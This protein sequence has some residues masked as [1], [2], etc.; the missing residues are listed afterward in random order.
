MSHQMENRRWEG[1]QAQSRHHVA[2]L[3]HR[4]IGHDPLDVVHHQAHGGRK[5]GG[6]AADQCH[7]SQD[8]LGRLKHRVEPGH[9]EHPGRHHSRG[10]D[11]GADRSRTLHR[12]GQPRMQRK[13]AG[14]SHSAGEDPQGQPGQPHTA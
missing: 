5:E 10:M 9:Q 6:E 3:A 11:Q 4:G 1:P 12:V 13:L 7:H 2:Q 14:L 8:V